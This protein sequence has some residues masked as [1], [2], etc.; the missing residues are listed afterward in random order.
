MIEATS[1]SGR[2]FNI[3]SLFEPDILTTYQFSKVFRE[4]THFGPEERLMFAVLTD[5]V[6]CFQK[7]LGANSRR[8]RALF[9]DAEAWINSKD[10]RWPFSFEH[11]CEMLRLS[12]SYLRMGLMRWRVAHET[13]KALHKRIREPLRYQ[14]RVRANRIGTYPRIVPREGAGRRRDTMRVDDR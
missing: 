8:C 6:E 14:Y 3:R 2:V 12:P 10:S 9:G 1:R 7:Y 13:K 5:A 4:K 11:I